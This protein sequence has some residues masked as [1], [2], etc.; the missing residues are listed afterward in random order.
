MIGELV[1][2][3]ACPAR[4]FPRAVRHGAVFFDDFVDRGVSKQAHL[5]SCAG[6]N[7]SS[8]IFKRVEGRLPGITQNVPVFAALKG[9]THQPRDRGAGGPHCVKLLIDDIRRHSVALKEISIKSPEIAVDRLGL[10]NLFNPIDRR[11]LAFVEKSGLL[12][13]LDLLHFAHQVIAKRRQMGRS[14]RSHATGNRPPID[15]NDRPAASA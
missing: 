14:P 2:M 9:N 5:T 11:R 4:T 12:R 15:D 13:T 8:Q 7:E 6:V 10:H 3:T 1:A